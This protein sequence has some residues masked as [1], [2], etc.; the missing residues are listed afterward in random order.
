MAVTRMA[1]A[2]VN[3]LN[4]LLFQWL[5]LS[6]V[7]FLPAFKDNTRQLQATLATVACGSIAALGVLALA[8][9]LFPVGAEI[10]SMIGLCWLLL[11]A[12]ALFDLCNEYSRATFSRGDIWPCRFRGPFPRYCSAPCSCCSE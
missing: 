1:L 5:R 4:A 8:I 12:Q 10:R 3:L 2:G 6:L 11:A 9:C 7:R